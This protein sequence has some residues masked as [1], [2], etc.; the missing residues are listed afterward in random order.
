MLGEVERVC[1]LHRQRAVWSDIPRSDLRPDFHPRRLRFR[2][3]NQSHLCESII[4]VQL[5]Q[6]YIRVLTSILLCFVE[7]A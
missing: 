5:S 2:L 1:D 7:G 4:S 6:N 3:P